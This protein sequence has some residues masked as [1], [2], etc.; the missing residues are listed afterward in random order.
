MGGLISR[1][2]INQFMPADSPDGR[3]QI[4]RLIML[5]TPNQGSPCADVMDFAFEMT[6]KN[7]EAIRQL[8]PSFLA[9]FNKVNVNRK[10]VKFSVLAGNPLPVMCKTVVWNDGVVPVESAIWK[11]K[12]H[13]LS[14]NVHTDL[15]GTADF[16]SFVKPRLAVGPK[17]N[18][19]PE[20]PDSSELKN[21]LNE[22]SR[23]DFASIFINASFKRTNASEQTIRKGFAKAVKLAP[24]QILEIEIPVKTA[25]DFGLTFMASN[26]V[27]AVLINDKS[28]V[29][30]K[31]LAKTIESNAWFRSIYINQ[32]VEQGNWSLKLEN[33]SDRE[34]E[35][36]LTTWNAAQ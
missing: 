36:F 27:S 21:Q 22:N 9:E 24:K 1:H 15:T 13:A 30:G 17:G 23:N 33:T 25:K 3:P 10:G 18:H 35:V 31:N 2:Y 4:S 26:Q 11:I 19:N 5:G 7:V 12:D 29:A 34:S 14:K 6:G 8:K 16:S 32:A 28:I 20:A